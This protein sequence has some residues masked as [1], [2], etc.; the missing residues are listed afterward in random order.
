MALYPI[1]PNRASS[2]NPINPPKLP[3][4]GLLRVVWS[5]HACVSRN[6]S[7]QVGAREWVIWTVMGGYTGTTI[8]VYSLVVILDNVSRKGR[9]HLKVCTYFLWVVEK[10]PLQR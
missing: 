1:N 4:F 9:L 10:K 8:E 6:D 3:K 2:I 7:L 5:P